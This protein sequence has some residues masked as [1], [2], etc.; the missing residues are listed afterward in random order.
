[1]EYDLSQ[2][3][4]KVN[5]LSEN[6]EQKRNKINQNR[7]ERVIDS[8]IFRNIEKELID[9]ELKFKKLLIEKIKYQTEYDKLMKEYSGLKEK[10]ENYYGGQKD[11]S[12]QK[13]GNASDGAI[14]TAY[15][16][17]PAPNRKFIEIESKN[18]PNR[19][20]TL[21]NIEEENQA[22]EQRQ[23][24]TIR[25]MLIESGLEDSEELL[26]YLQ[27]IES[28]NE[29]SF[30]EM[31]IYADQVRLHSCRAMKSKS[32]LLILR[33]RKG[34]KDSTSTLPSANSPRTRPS[35]SSAAMLSRKLHNP[36][37]KSKSPSTKSPTYSYLPPYP[38]RT[39]L[40]QVSRRGR[41]PADDR[42]NRV[43]QQLRRNN[44]YAAA[45][46]AEDA[47]VHPPLEPHPRGEGGDFAR[48]GAGEAGGV[49]QPGAEVGRVRQSDEEGGFP[50]G[51][52]EDREEQF[53]EEFG[54]QGHAQE[55]EFGDDP[56]VIS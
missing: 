34:P 12:K 55:E 7:M 40:P 48:S 26:Y 20:P 29:K 30:N 35:T 33:I 38:E 42:Q 31:N 11:H 28:I 41:D 46:G 18:A 36:N 5:R 56:Q 43:N 44:G 45:A 10:A 24:I 2:T 47:G 53:A 39:Q 8:G 14:P 23:I 22:Y 16:A 1:L 27:N 6:V 17:H 49:H 19:S 54:R 32:I 15:D 21:K 37:R 51:V 50:G 25:K 3:N 9:S 4:S 52:Q 13:I